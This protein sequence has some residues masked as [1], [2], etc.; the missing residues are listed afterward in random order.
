M[1]SAAV[2]GNGL[3]VL[4]LEVRDLSKKQRNYVTVHRFRPARHRSRSGEAGGPEPVN[5]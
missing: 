4:R 2:K 3:R 5:T 1:I